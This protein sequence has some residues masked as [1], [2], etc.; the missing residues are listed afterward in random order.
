AVHRKRFAYNVFEE[1]TGR[2]SNTQGHLELLDKFVKAIGLTKE[3]VNSVVPHPETK[4][5]IDYRFSLI[6]DPNTFH[7]A[8][9][10]VMIA[11]EGQNLEERVG[12]LKRDMITGGFGLQPADVLFFKVHAEEDVYHVKDGI[13]ATADVCTTETM[14]HEAIEAIHETCDKFWNF[15]EGISKVYKQQQQYFVAN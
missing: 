3:D 14:Q 4:E 15:Y 13:N 10:A 1:E 2:I 12:T 11:S 5:L 8:V 7:K 6:E 9:A